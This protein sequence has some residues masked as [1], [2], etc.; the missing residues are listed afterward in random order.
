MIMKHTINFGSY[1][2]T[3]DDHGAELVSLTYNKKEYM[4]QGS[5]WAEHA[6]V[7][8]P[9]VGRVAGTVSYRGQEYTM[10]KHGFIKDRDLIV[11]DKTE[12]SLTLE[13]KWADCDYEVFPF[14]FIFRAI[15]ALGEG[16]LKVD[17]EV[18][19]LDEKEM[20]LQFGWHPGFALHGEGSIENF[21]LDFGADCCPMKHLTTETKF[22]SG[23]VSSFPL[24]NGVYKLSEEEIYTDD[25]IILSETLGKVVMASPDTPE[26]LTLTYTD[27]LPYLAIWK[28][29][30]TEARYLCLEPWGGIPS[31]GVSKEVLEE[32]VSRRI[33]PGATE[34][35]S[36]TVECK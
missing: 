17:F 1:S 29:P 3:V 16:G 13:Y 32:R 2:A 6:P 25:T 35:Y 19:N 18:E 31:D 22:V 26:V 27:N 30:R 21:T 23:A 10:P 12:S 14:K 36:Y 4:W 15:F 28:W 9:I 5:I 33:A 34:V 11:V 8:F 20:I 24:D 7:L